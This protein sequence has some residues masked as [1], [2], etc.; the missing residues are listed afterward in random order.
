MSSSGLYEMEETMSEAASSPVFDAS[1]PE[2]G[3]T[4]IM[5]AGMSAVGGSAQP[6]T[7]SALGDLKDDV[8][9]TLAGV[10]QTVKDMFGAAL[11]V[12][13]QIWARQWEHAWFRFAVLA[14][15]LSL[16]VLFFVL[17]LME[18]PL[19][20]I[21]FSGLFVILGT[22]FLW[23]E[24]RSKVS[25][26]QVAGGLL[27]QMMLGSFIMK[28]QVGYDL[29]D[30]LGAEVN[31]L[32]AFSDM[33]AN[34]VFGDYALG[35]VVY[36]KQNITVVTAATYAPSLDYTGSAD[37]N[38]STSALMTILNG[39]ASVVE[40]I[41]S[42]SVSPA[43]PTFAVG[44]LPSII[45]FSA[46]VEILNHVGI[47]PVVMSGCAWIFGFFAAVS[48][49]E[50]VSAAA[51]V[52]VGMTNAPLL[53]KQALP[54]ATNSQLMAVMVG[55]FATV[56]GSMIPVYM[57]FGAPGVHLLAA[58]WMG[59]PASLTLSKILVPDTEAPPVYTMDQ[60]RPEKCKNVLEA[61]AVGVNAGLEIALGVAAMLITFVAL[62]KLFDASLASFCAMVGAKA[63]TS[64]NLFGYFFS[65]LAAMMGVDFKDI[66][67]CGAL[68]GQKTFINEFLAFDYLSKLQSCP[69]ANCP[70]D[71]FEPISQR[72]LNII[73][74]ALCGFSNFS[75]I[76][77]T[78]ASVGAMIPARMG[79]LSTYCFRAMIA[80]LLANCMNAC[81]AG[82]LL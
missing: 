40:V 54:E 48:P 13:A 12:F 70:V 82:L 6:P 31:A 79:D 7:R 29:F 24:D 39:T 52:F 73:T 14:V 71:G 5:G 22:C 44:V 53:I 60:I 69:S 27:L 17:H 65:P 56:A 81:I 74:Y 55:G 68:L 45:F 37:L 19:R 4:S 2:D 51:N 58:A 72:S 43:G 80:G 57:L 25:L 66:L 35:K 11:T 75:A 49:M 41:T 15:L 18:E 30:W 3:N 20:I 16:F 78:L 36:E 63:V 9:R 8:G 61:I 59:A 21:S 28:T 1:V 47:L 10:R 62:A 26:R 76:G 64:N 42:V 67:P 34:F 38:D 77:M 33:G 32:L 23:S 50:S 46:L